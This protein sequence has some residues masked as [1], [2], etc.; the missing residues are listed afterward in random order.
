MIVS[1]KTN[2]IT[3]KNCIVNHITI[4][5]IW[6]YSNDYLFHLIVEMYSKQL[7][8]ALSCI[9]KSHHCLHYLSCTLNSFDYFFH[10][11]LIKLT[12]R[13]SNRFTET[14]G[15]CSFSESYVLQPACFVLAAKENFDMFNNSQQI[16]LVVCF[17]DATFNGLRYNLE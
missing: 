16:N 2:I 17:L 12:W 15:I 4:S 10:F 1:K 8:V 3:I 11:S 14:I 7:N 6:L 9:Q 13:R 5:I